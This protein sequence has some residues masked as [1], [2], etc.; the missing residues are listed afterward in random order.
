MTRRL[1]DFA[2]NNNINLAQGKF[3]LASPGGD[4]SEG[5]KMATC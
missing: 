1:L 2:V 5:L 3:I 4:V